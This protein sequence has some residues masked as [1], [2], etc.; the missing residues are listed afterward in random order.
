MTGRNLSLVLP[1]VAVA[2]LGVL[3]VLVVLDGTAFVASAIPQ[4]RPLYDST[5][6]HYVA[7]T[8]V[9]SGDCSTPA[10]VCLTVQY[11]I[12]QAGVGD[13]IR[14]AAG[15]YTGVQYI[16][17]HTQTVNLDKTVILRGGYTTGNWTAPDPALNRTI[18]D[19]EGQGR[20]MYINVDAAPTIDGFILT[21][22][23]T[24]ATSGFGAGIYVQSGVPLFVHSV[25]TGNVTD[26]S[27]GGGFYVYTDARVVVSASQVISNSS[28]NGG[29]GFNFASGSTG[30]L[31]GNL[32]S[33]NTSSYGNGVSMWQAVVTATAN[34]FMN[35][36]QLDALRCGGDMGY[37]LLINNVIASN[38]DIG[39]SADGGCQ[40]YA[41]HNTIVS[42]TRRGVDASYGAIMTLTSNIIADHPYYESI[43]V[44][45]AQPTT[46]TAF[47]NLY[48]NNGS[49][50]VTGMGDVFGDPMFVSP[51]NSDLHIG[52]GSA[53][54]DQAW[55]FTG[56]GQDID[57]E[58]RPIGAGPDMGAD[59][60]AY[61]TYLP[62]ML[63]K[64]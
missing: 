29:A 50:P 24:D 28:V 55:A 2:A 49:D 31:H 57:G 36:R 58:P 6:V 11:A 16:G 60:R 30:V 20:V 45:P 38:S 14:V 40:V 10:S 47:Y 21:G 54:I 23:W 9:D 46:V 41:V 13:E 56:V 12:T 62:I 18:L 48:W 27:Y 5:P 39:V 25:I 34:T 15:R 8:G 52:P 44:D 32:V 7:T 61:F 37:L 3:A 53:A 19:A 33:R 26:S 64:N 1:A 17:G 51:D 4:A 63:R 59:E 35:N 42:N 22:G 43:F